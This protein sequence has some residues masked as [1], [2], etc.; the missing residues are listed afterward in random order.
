M[1]L[2]LACLSLFCAVSQAKQ[3]N[4][5]YWQVV[6]VWCVCA[7]VV[8]VLMVPPGWNSSVKKENRNP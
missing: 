4:T 7:C 5:K 1:L 3:P 6:A 2:F 8:L